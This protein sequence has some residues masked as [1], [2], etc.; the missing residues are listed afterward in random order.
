[1]NNQNKHPKEK[2][3]ALVGKLTKL[4]KWHVVECRPFTDKELENFEPFAE[5][6]EGKYGHSVQ[7]TCSSPHKEHVYIPL[8][9]DEDYLKRSLYVNELFLVKLARHSDS[10]TLSRIA[11]T[12]VETVYTKD[13]WEKTLQEIREEK[14]R[15]ASLGVKVTIF[16]TCIPY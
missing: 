12:P 10:T 4:S 6:V 14:D 11:I 1:M 16:D 15:L 13:E 2:L 3:Y 9:R 5:I 7:F 8:L